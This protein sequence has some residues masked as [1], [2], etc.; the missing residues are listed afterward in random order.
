[1]KIHPTFLVTL[2]GAMAGATL[3]G[4]NAE[5]DKQNNY[6]GSAPVANEVKDTNSTRKMAPH[7]ETGQTKIQPEDV[8]FS[9]GISEIV[10]MVKSDTD[11]AVILTYVENSPIA[12]YPS[13]EEIIY[14]HQLGTPPP[15]V[16]A[17]I[18]HGGEL[19]AQA[20]KAYKENQ[21]ANVQPTSPTIVAPAA[22][23]PSAV[24]AYNGYPDY[25]YNYATY[26][27]G[28][29]PYYTYPYYTYSYWNPFYYAYSYPRYCGYPG[30][31]YG[32]YGY[33]GYRYG[34]CAPRHH[35]Y[36]YNV[37]YRGGGYRSGGYYGVGYRG[38][39][40]YHGGGYR[41]GGGYHGGGYRGG[42]PAFGHSG[43]GMARRGR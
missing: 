39:G 14:L 16:S 2:A 30:Y 3:L 23:A 11:S 38:G 22:Q 12:F 18:R 20:A 43:G 19:R 35:G 29:Y 25:G 13:A 42:S 31:R 10:R 41:G 17:L 34:Y 36:A 9:A 4:V 1:M 40:G 7:K 28:A 32:Y 5:L 6:S 24:A 37:G 15:I 33:P 8:K 26:S 27:Y 21:K